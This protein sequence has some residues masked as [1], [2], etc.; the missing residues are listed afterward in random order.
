MINRGIYTPVPTFFKSDLKTIDLDTQVA[1]ARFLRDNGIAGLV[2]MGST[3]ELAHLTLAE[4]HTIVA[5]LREKVPEL[6]IFGGVG[7]HSVEGALEEIESLKSAGASY[8]LVLPSS[9]YGVSITQQGIVDWY[10]EVADRAVLPVV[11]YVYP[12][13]TN[14]VVV[15]PSTI[16]TL[17]AHPNIV[18][19]KISHGDLAHH[20]MLGL[21]PA[22]AANG[23][24]CLTGLG[25]VLLPALSVGFA[26]TVDA[27]SG[28]F[29]RLYVKILEHY[30]KGEFA[31]AQQLQLVATRGE[32]L[33]VR[34]GVVGIK[35]AIY[36]ATGFGETY[37][38]RAPL[39]HD[40][41]G[42]WDSYAP[43]FQ[44]CVEE[45]AKTS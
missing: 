38:G 28:A 40:T 43:Y 25:Q 16:K 20:A 22:V 42:D 4:R 13:V 27:L 37:L 45:E 30:D 36:E 39:N 14:G 41:T 5:T 35:R 15:Q 2:V 18:G 24:A 6:P 17:S 8:A 44:G 9:Y 34:F 19:T 31:Q 29:P 23:F 26:G 7:Q 32:E 12:G 33:V 10:T 21:D 3:G 11:V 1:H